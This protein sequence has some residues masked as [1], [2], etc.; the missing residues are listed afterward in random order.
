MCYLI[1]L[2]WTALDDGSI[3]CRTFLLPKADISNNQMKD[4]GKY[5]VTHKHLFKYCEGFA[6][7]EKSV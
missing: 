5:I 1:G 3:I 7:G 4:F 6:F 2:N